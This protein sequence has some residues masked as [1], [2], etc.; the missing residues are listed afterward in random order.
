MKDVNSVPVR[1]ATICVG[2]EGSINSLTRLSRASKGMRR[3]GGRHGSLTNAIGRHFEDIFSKVQVEGRDPSHRWI[4]L[5][6]GS[7]HEVAWSIERGWWFD[8]TFQ[9]ADRV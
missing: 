9:R 1:L 3:T 8:A 6:C 2:D 7:E 4:A 5:S